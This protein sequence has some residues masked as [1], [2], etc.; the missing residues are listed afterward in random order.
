MRGLARAPSGWAVPGASG[1]AGTLARADAVAKRR[2][3]YPA[4]R[5]ADGRLRPV[6]CTGCAQI[7]DRGEHELDAR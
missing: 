6:I 7:L 2:L 4:R 5:L 3:Y 1:H